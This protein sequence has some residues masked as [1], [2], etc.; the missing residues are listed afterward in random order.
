MTRRLCWALKEVKNLIWGPSYGRLKKSSPKSGF[1]LG[2]PHSN[3]HYDLKF[4]Q[5]HKIS[6]TSTE[7]RA[8]GLFW[9]LEF[10]K[11]LISSLS[12][13][14]YRLVPN[15]GTFWRIFTPLR[16]FSC[17]HCFHFHYV[18]FFAISFQTPLKNPSR[19][20]SGTK[21]SGFVPPALRAGFLRGVIT[22]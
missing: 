3:S 21:A 22:W 4:W 11:N 13:G 12:Y 10:L 17:F 9:A 1:F 18:L 5:N 7:P 15:R 2:Y 16:T 20:A 6:K 8:W 14:R 19:R